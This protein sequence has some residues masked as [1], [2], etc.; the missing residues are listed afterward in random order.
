VTLA[1][2]LLLF[3]FQQ[4]A[5]SP[6][7]GWQALLYQAGQILRVLLLFLPQ[8]PAVPLPLGRQAL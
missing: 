2:G 1:R 5:V 8:L 4:L 3:L 6:R 7:L